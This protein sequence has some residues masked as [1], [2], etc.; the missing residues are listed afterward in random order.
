MSVHVNWSCP[1]NDLFPARFTWLMPYLHAMFHQLHM[2]QGSFRDKISEMIRHLYSLSL[3]LNS[4]SRLSDF[5]SFLY[6]LN[7]NLK[8]SSD[9]FLKSFPNK[10]K[11]QELWYKFYLKEARLLIW[12]S[13]D[14]YWKNIRHPPNSRSQVFVLMK[15]D[16]VSVVP[17]NINLRVGID[18]RCNNLDQI[19]TSTLLTKIINFIWGK[20]FK[21]KYVINIQFSI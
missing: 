15:E 3:R 6:F 7:L 10:T 20:K 9:L 1:I 11:Q 16:Q 2:Q 5:L 17:L 13:E 8:I 21:N 18:T 14:S 4:L 12:V 19:S